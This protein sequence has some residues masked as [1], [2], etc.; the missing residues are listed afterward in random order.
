MPS[1]HYKTPRTY[2]QRA[3]T[4]RK[5]APKAERL[6]WNALSALRT[7]TKLHFRRQHPLPPYIADFACVKA[8]LIIELDGMSHDMRQAY[9]KKRDTELS[10]R[11]WTVM[12]FSNEEIERNLD[13]VTL[14]ILETTRTR[15]PAHP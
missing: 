11:G 8:R 12:R 14:T 4:L 5:L 10:R 2:G 1:F 13:G 9:D 6:L 3:K 7:E 15:L